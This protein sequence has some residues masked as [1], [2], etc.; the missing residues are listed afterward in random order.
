[1][2]ASKF[3][4]TKGASKIIEYRNDP[5]KYAYE[6]FGFEPDKWQENALRAFGSA[7]PLDQQI[8]LQACVGPGKTAVLA[9][10]GWNFLSC[11][12]DKG[13]HPKG[14][15][16]SITADNLKDNLWPE[17]SKWQARSEWL[18]RAFVWQKE[19]IF[20]KDHPETWFISARSWAKTANPDEQGRTLS[21]LHSKYVLVLIDESGDIPLTV[22]KAGQQ[23]R[24]NCKFGKIVQAG[25]PTSQEGML[26]AAATTLRHEWRVIIITGD[27][28]DPERSPRI[29][30]TWARNQIKNHGRE[31]PWV[32][33]T[34]LGKFPPSSFNTL[35]SVEEVQAA[36]GRLLR[37]EM[38]SFSQRRLGVD[39]ARFGDDP[40]VIF[41]RQG[42]RAFP[43][44]EM[45]NPRSQDVAARIALARQRWD[46]EMAYFDDTGG[47]AAGAI[48]ASIQAGLP[49]TPV[50][51]SS[52][53]TDPRYY[54]KRAEMWFTMSE[55]VK[56]GGWLPKIDFLIGELTI[57]TYTFMKGKF[58][59]EEKDQIKERLGRS[60]NYA[61][62]LALTFAFPD[63]PT[64]RINGLELQPKKSNLLSE[65]DPLREIQERVE[66]S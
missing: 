46:H 45:R 27:P 59:I 22:L 50:N 12:G 5:V 54:N 61:D 25:N 48:D 66:N 51:F 55:W 58:I 44:V 3:L 6:I 49:T 11:Y 41:P 37:E 35:L 40:W 1:M 64:Q 28:D 7:E 36:M 20:C 57:P 9:I 31:N 8:S 23:A 39:A 65:W 13:E 16:V 33:A 4:P 29:D 52:K 38:Y 24:S 32:M 62:A 17:F 19:R 18:K 47:Y 14:A 30:I 21:G 56:K 63:A 10:M 15:A 60:P 53:A 43:A 34:I 26:Y 42:L 2:P